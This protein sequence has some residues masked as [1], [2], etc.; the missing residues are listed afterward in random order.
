MALFKD[1]LDAAMGLAVA[2]GRY[3]GSRPLVLAIPRGAVVMGEVL[4]RELDGELDV[5][6]AR[7]LPAPFE[8]ELAIGS[9]GEGGRIHVDRDLASAVGADDG[10]IARKAEEVRE[11]IR[12]RRE[13]Y[14]RVRPPVDPAGRVA[15]ICDD[16]VATGSTMIA[17]LRD[18][19]DRRPERLVAAFAV[20]PPEAVEAIRGHADEVVPLAVREDF[21]AVSQF[22]GA[23][24][25]VDDA[26]VVE[27]LA[28]AGRGGPPD[29]PR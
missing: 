8:P 3:R 24:E 20:A 27:I 25:Q 21:L 10:Y 22:F 23:F 16:G 14:A 4:A 9:V 7:K 13:R 11:L 18:V 6:L 28:R 26:E 5:V 1:R 17:A 2:L 12:A 19:R 29:P 15:I